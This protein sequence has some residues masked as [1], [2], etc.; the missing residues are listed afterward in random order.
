MPSSRWNFAFPLTAGNDAEPL[1]VAVWTSVA[2]LAAGTAMSAAAARMPMMEMVIRV[3]MM[4]SKF[5]SGDCARVASDWSEMQLDMG[6]RTHRG[7]VGLRSYAEWGVGGSWEAKRQGLG[8]HGFGRRD[9]VRPGRRDRACHCRSRQRPRPAPRLPD[10][11][12]Q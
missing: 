1:S 7:V 2:A 10:R 9:Q 11:G 12:A 4:S 3:R 8:A 6:L 5:G